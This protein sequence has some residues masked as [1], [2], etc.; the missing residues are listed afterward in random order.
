MW[1][2]IRT[3]T[4]TVTTTGSAGSATGTSTSNQMYGFLLDIY[5]DFH[6]SAPATTDT[7]VAY[8]TPANGNIIVLSNT[9]TDVLHAPRKQASDATGAAISGVYDLFPLNGTVTISLAQSDA[10]TGALIARIRY[11][12]FD[13]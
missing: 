10:L 2:P 11:V 7:T 6:A 1:P 4:V 13:R 3:E 8:G 9:A 5:F 12:T